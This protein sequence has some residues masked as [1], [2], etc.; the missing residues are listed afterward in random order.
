M[1]GLELPK[2]DKALVINKEK[3][4]SN[5]TEDVEGIC[6]IGLSYAVSASPYFVLCR[7]CLVRVQDKLPNA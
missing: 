1:L 2:F 3:S 5:I 6:I 4:C 7:V